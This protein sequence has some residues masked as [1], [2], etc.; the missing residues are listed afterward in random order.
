MISDTKYIGNEL[1]IF[2][3]ATNWKKYFS[4]KIAT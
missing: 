3:N 1:D 4:S 2:S